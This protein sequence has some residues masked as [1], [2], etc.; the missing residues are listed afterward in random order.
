MFTVISG[1]RQPLSTNVSGELVL[2]R[3]VTLTSL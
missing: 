2:A 1:F 3:L